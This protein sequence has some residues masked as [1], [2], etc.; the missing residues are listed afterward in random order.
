MI[1]GIASEYSRWPLIS[2]ARRFSQTGFTKPEGASLNRKWAVTVLPGAI[3][4]EG[5]VL[6]HP[7]FY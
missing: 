1:P 7:N 3:L 5:H 4:S 6:A 2:I